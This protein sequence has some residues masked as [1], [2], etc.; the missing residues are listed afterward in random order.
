MDAKE[1]VSTAM[2]GSGVTQTQMAALL[3]MTG[4]SGFSMALNRS[5]LKVGFFVRALNVLGYEV[6]VKKRTRGRKEEGV[7]TVTPPEGKTGKAIEGQSE[8]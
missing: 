5:D 4:Q 6:V 8:A 3:G 1:I 7:I 2:K